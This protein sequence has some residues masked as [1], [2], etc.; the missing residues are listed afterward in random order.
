[1]K[2]N[3]SADIIIAFEC[4]MTLPTEE[5]I[6]LQKKIQNSSFSENFE[7]LN[8]FTPYEEVLKDKWQKDEICCYYRG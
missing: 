7:I 2:K 1:M 8:P 5:F 4:P 6:E 3:K